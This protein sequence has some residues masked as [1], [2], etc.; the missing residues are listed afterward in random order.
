MSN[1]S[2]SVLLDK[3]IISVVL[4]LLL[5]VYLTYSKLYFKC[6]GNSVL[7]YA[8]AYKHVYYGIKP[9]GIQLERLNST[10]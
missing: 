10:N 7:H 8:S 2:R 3:D 6:I 4:D 1:T 5:G 9:K